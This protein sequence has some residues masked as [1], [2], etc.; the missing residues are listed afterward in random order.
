M[1]PNRLEAFSDGVIAIIITIMVLELK[2]PTSH[3]VW[4]LV[5]L[6]PH[7]AAYALSFFI[8]GIHWLNHHR[9]VD[10]LET[11]TPGFLWVNLIMLFWLSLVPFAT[12]YMGHHHWRGPSLAIYIG[13]VIVCNLFLIVL[14]VLARQRAP[15]GSAAYREQ[16]VGLRRA[17]FAL[18]VQAA[19]GALA[20]FYPLLALSLMGLLALISFIA[21]MRAPVAAEAAEAAEAA[22]AE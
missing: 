16:T 4:A 17:L 13:L 5:D 18:G 19:A 12:A 15:A 7:F 10:R 1:K 14:R 6:A 20:V 22:A 2:V 3:D 9:M 21:L 8:I 11:V